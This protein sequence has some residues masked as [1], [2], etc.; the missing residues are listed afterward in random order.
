MDRDARD[1]RDEPDVAVLV[2]SPL[3]APAQSPLI[4]SRVA[5]SILKCAR[6][7]RLQMFPPSLLVSL[8]GWGLTDLPLRT[9]NEGLPISYT[10]L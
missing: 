8:K 7:T 10:S 2:D 4:S 5:W 1:M 6:R 9:S 3:R